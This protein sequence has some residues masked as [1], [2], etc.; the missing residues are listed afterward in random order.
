[1]KHETQSRPK[2]QT[3]KRQARASES[4]KPKPVSS[5]DLD[6]LLSQFPTSVRLSYGSAKGGPTTWMKALQLHLCVQQRSVA[7]R[8]IVLI[9]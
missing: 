7:L 6:A 3:A 5:D 8:Q 9:K 4:Q 2:R 1:M